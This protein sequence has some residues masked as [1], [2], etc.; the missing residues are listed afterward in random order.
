MGAGKTS[1]ARAAAAAL[2][3]PRGRHRPR[4]R[5]AARHARS[6]STSPPTASGRSATPRRTRS[7]SCSSAAGAGALA[8]RRRGHLRARARALAATR[9][10]CSTSTTTPPGGA[11]AG[12]GRSRATARASP[13]CSPSAAPLYDALADAVLPDPR[14][15]CVRRARAGAARA[16]PA[17]RAGTRLLW[18]TARLGRVPGVR[19]RRAARLAASG[20]STG[21]ALLVTDDDGRR[22]STATRSA[23]VVDGRRSSRGRPPRRSRTA[24]TRA[25]RRSPRPGSTT[26]TTWSRS[27]AAWSATWPASAP[28]STSAACAVVQVPTTLVAQ[29]DSA[30]GGKTGVDLPRARTTSAP[31]TSR[32]RC[33]PTR[34][35]SRRCRAEELAAG[36]AEVVKTALIAGGPLWK[37]VRAR[38]RRGRPRPRAG[39]RAHEARAS[40]P[41]TSATP[42]RRQILNLGHTVGHAIETVTGYA[43]YRHGEAVGLGLLA[44][45]T[46]S[47]Q[48][49]LREEVAGLLAA[50]GLPT[51]LDPAST[52]TPSSPPPRATR[53]AAA[54]ASASCWSRRRATCAP[55]C[56][57]APDD[58]R[59][60]VAELERSMRNRVAVLHGVNLDALDRRPAEHYGGLTLRAAGAADRALRPRARARGALLPDQPRGRVRRGAA[61]GRA[62]TPTG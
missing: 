33:S 24:E 57:V 17:R 52:P 53:S 28:R 51:Q 58:L 60:A 9:S 12:A 15:T 32:R 55:A 14:A 22:R 48:P 5:G 7:S 42:A 4:A 1:A 11:P 26:T 36:W 47:A 27:A 16:A 38:A 37:R 6:R 3:A 40:S 45:L 31:T 30:Y 56:A 43:R 62:T 49:A 13:R 18:A 44:A 46:L 59:A 23:G 19:R 61:Q 35:R 54:G 25:A 29:V 39:L 21:A 50:R 2:G 41:P 34:A 20:R 10:C 8:R